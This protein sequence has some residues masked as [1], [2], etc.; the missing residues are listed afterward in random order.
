MAKAKAAAVKEEDTV[1]RQATPKPA[2]EPKPTPKASDVEK[3]EVFTEFFRNDAQNA[4][5]IYLDD[6]PDFKVISVVE[7]D[8]GDAG[9]TVTITYK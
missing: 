7:S 8:A 9:T 4:A 5:Q 6:N 3:V 1:K 2:P